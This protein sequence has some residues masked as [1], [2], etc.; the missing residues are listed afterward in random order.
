MNYKHL[1]TQLKHIVKL[2]TIPALALMLSSCIG[3]SDTMK[4][5]SDLSLDKSIIS[6][7]G[8][9]VVNVTSVRGDM[10]VRIDRIDVV[11]D[12]NL[13]TQKVDAS[14]CEGKSLS[15]NQS[16][17]FIINVA[18]SQAGRVTINLHGEYGYYSKFITIDTTGS[19]II[20]NDIKEVRTTK[21]K[22]IPVTNYGKMAVKMNN[23][24]SAYL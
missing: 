22:L 11:N 6:R 9:H 15:P 10:S 19:G 7:E 13:T 1:L 18:E 14:D 24:A 8:E 23:E 17:K 4:K 16:C 21:Y 2:S 3:D 12:E 5:P 20:D